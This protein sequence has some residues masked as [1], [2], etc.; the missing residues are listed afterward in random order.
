MFIN[1]V[2]AT[3]FYI[4]VCSFLFAKENVHFRGS[5]KSTFSDYGVTIEGGSIC[6]DEDYNKSCFEVAIV[7][8]NSK[9]YGR[10]FNGYLIASS[11]LGTLE[12]NS[13][14]EFHEYINFEKK[15]PL[16]GTYYVAILLLQFDEIYDYAVWDNPI[17]FTNKKDV[18]VESL[19]N[20]LRNAQEQVSRYYRRN[21]I[22]FDLD[23]FNEQMK[24]NRKF[25]RIQLQ[26][27]DL[28]CSTLGW[29]RLFSPS[30][31]KEPE[32]KYLAEEISYLP[33]Y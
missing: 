13:S 21:S 4:F 18:E 30:Y 25:S 14:V 28:G 11:R 26:L 32:K 3:V 20:D 24:W 12:A 16:S 2:F 31:N 19:L 17:Y 27:L 10:I 33:K 29:D 5:F 1:K 22:S 6:N 23:D 9:Y 8:S 7:F 15:L